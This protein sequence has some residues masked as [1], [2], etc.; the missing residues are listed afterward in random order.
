MGYHEANLSDEAK[1]LHRGIAS[2][3]EEWEAVDWYQQRIDVSADEDL[4]AVLAHN[5]DEEIEHAVMALEWLRR[6]LPYL[7]EQ[8]RTYLFTTGSIHE[9]HEAEKHGGSRPACSGKDLGIGKIEAQGG[10]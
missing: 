10:E 7:D 8:L 1:D 4:K 3:I 2:L 5:R 6:K 9:L